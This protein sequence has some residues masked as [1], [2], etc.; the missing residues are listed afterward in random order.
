MDDKTENLRDIFL[1]VADDDAVTEHQSADRGSLTGGPDAPDTRLN[2]VF[3]AIDEKFGFETPLSRSQRRS[4]LEL[5]YGGVSD[6]ELAADLG[7]DVETI[8]D[9]RME[10]HL[11]RPEEP[12]L[13][14]SLGRRIW[15]QPDRAP[16]DLAEAMD[17]SVPAVARTRAVLDARDRSR[18]VSH[19]FRSTFDE[20]FTDGDISDRLATET[21]EDGL[22]EATEDA[23]T[24]VE[25]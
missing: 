12:P 23:E 2:A 1:S 16:A 9:A 5:F 17:V 19:R 22:G 15:D 21:R 20:L 10:L 4:L 7:Y 6:E 11:W 8:F 13:S 18:R 24:D 25:F 14:E 3:D